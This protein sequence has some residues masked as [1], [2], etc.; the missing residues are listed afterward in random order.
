V[1]T[2]RRRKITRRRDSDPVR[3]FKDGRIAYWTGGRPGV[4]I[5][6][7]DRRPSSEE[8]QERALE[9]RLALR[10]GH[11]G[12][13]PRADSTLDELMQAA[14]E[15]LRATRAPEGSIVSTRRIGTAGSP[16]PSVTRHAATHSCG[17]TRRSSTG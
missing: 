5:R 1:S 10:A 11:R 14:L 16:K 2:S 6:K 12:A 7:W 9:L 15:D 8:A 4:G 13:V 17:T 3:V